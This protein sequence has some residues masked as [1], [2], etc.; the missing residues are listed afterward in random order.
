[1]CKFYRRVKTNSLGLF[2]AVVVEIQ[3]Y[4]DQK[5]L[6]HIVRLFNSHFKNYISIAVAFFKRYFIL[7]IL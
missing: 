2:A 1:M 7:L 4:G 3:F 5:W 6:R